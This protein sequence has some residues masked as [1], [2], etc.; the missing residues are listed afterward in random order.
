MEFL[1]LMILLQLGVFDID[2]NLIENLIVSFNGTS[3]TLSDQNG[4]CIFPSR[5]MC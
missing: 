4:I 1:N 3:D 2:T 5:C